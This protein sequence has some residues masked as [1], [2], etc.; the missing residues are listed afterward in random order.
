MKSQFKLEEREITLLSGRK[1][2]I[3]ESIG[4]DEKALVDTMSKGGNK[5]YYDA[6]FAYAQACTLEIDGQK[7]TSEILNDLLAGDFDF[8]LIAIRSLSFGSDMNFELK[9]SQDS[10]GAKNAF[11]IDINEILDKAKPYPHGN[12]RT[13]TTN[14]E[15]VEVIYNLPTVKSQRHVVMSNERT[16]FSVLKSVNPRFIEEG[17]EMPL[18]LETVK[19]RH[20]NAL[21]KEILTKQH[22]L[23]T[24]V[25]LTCPSCGTRYENDLKESVDFFFPSMT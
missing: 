7:V 8:L 6:T 2:K 24:T 21:K 18:M 4:A 3:R 22:N 23:D 12:E 10:C 17:V 25:T 11:T 9:C 20:F 14:I 19:G 5:K 13:F 1:A 15:G 16:L